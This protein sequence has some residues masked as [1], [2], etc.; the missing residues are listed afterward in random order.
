MGRQQSHIRTGFFTAL[1]VG[2]F[3][4]LAFIAWRVASAALEIAF[5]FVAGWVLALLL[6]PLVD[7]LQ[8]RGLGRTPAVGIVF[9]W[10][11][12][13]AVCLGII[14]LP[15]IASQATML[16]D[17]SPRY[18][19]TIKATTND[20]LARHRSVGSYALPQN[21]DALFSQISDQVS[22]IARNS[23]GKASDLLVGSIGTLIE[24][25]VMVIVS[26]YL[27]VDLNVL[28][29]R[30]FFLM[31]DRFI[32]LFTELVADVG[33][34]FSNYLR[35]LIIVCALYGLATMG[36]LYGLAIAHSDLRHYALLVGAIGGILYCVPYA[37]PFVTALITFLVAFA[38]GGIGFGG[39]AVALTL[40]VNQVFDN[41]V[42]PR[43]VGGGVGLH[44]VLSLFALTLGGALFGIWGLLLSVPVTASVQAILF[45]LFPILTAPTPEAYLE[46]VSAPKPSS[47]P[48]ARKKLPRSKVEKT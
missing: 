16:A 28:R 10:F 9:G 13:V 5:P 25:V 35:G 34:V 44:P 45:R 2:L 11:L 29:A 23:A 32:A 33:E 24:L 47:I 12:L 43:V 20:F 38:A 31:P 26:F 8:R 19:V 7:R 1:G 40:L 30:L 15:I 46:P 14:L 3:A 42:T 17:D 6:N 48:A 27:L 41:L 22:G 37:G 39:I 4:V 36:L 21:F 18:I